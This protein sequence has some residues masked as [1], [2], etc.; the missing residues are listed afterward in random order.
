VGSFKMLMRY[1]L[2]LTCGL[3]FLMYFEYHILCK[4]STIVGNKIYEKAITSVSKKPMKWYTLTHAPFIS[5]KLNHVSF[6]ISRTT[7]KYTPLSKMS[8]ISSNT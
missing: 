5:D 8:S 7:N 1:E 3:A 2:V 6:H 4:V